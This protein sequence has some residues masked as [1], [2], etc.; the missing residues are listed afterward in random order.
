MSQP[1]LDYSAA[2]QPIYA[3]LMEASLA[4]KKGGLDHKLLILVD[5]RASQLNGCAFC[6][7]MHSKQ[8]KLAGERE[9]RLYALAAWHESPL[10]TDREKA[11]LA[12]TDAVTKLGT[13]GVPDE[14]WNQVREQ[15]SDAEIA[16][17]TMAIGMINLWNRLSVSFRAVPGSVDKQFGLDRAGLS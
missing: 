13:Y 8:A 3:K 12:W 10:F 7:D 9:L 15:F 5:L 6:I 16:Q 17:L 2:Q 14:V 4:I 11:A 1:R